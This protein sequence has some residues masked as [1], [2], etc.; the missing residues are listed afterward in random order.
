MNHTCSIRG[1]HGAR[2]TRRPATATLRL[3]FLATFNRV[4]RRFRPR[5]PTAQSAFASAHFAG[6]AQPNA[7]EGS[8][9]PGTATLRLRKNAP[10]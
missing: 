4:R 1:G 8:V 7:R 10:W 3:K 9:G 2:P 5:R 6:P